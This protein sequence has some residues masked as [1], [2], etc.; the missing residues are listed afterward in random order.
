M[1]LTINEKYFPVN[2]YRKKDN[3]KMKKIYL[4][5]MILFILIIYIG[6]HSKI[7]ILSLLII[8]FSVLYLLLPK[9]IVKNNPNVIEEETIFEPIKESPIDTMLDQPSWKRHE[10]DLE[11][12]PIEG[13]DNNYEEWTKSLLRW[14]YKNDI[15]NNCIPREAKKLIKL[16]SLDLSNQGISELP[17]EIGNLFYLQELN[18]SNNLLTEIP[19]EISNL[20]NLSILNLSNNKLKRRPRVLSRL[21]YLTSLRLDN[22]NIYKQSPEVEAF[23]YL[24]GDVAHRRAGVREEDECNL[25]NR[26]NEKDVYLK[27]S[28]QLVYPQEI[29]NFSTDS[30]L[31]VAIPKKRSI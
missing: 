14:A 9:R 26:A 29:P 16:I 8:P 24:L 18:L 6:N 5:L 31:D 12:L 27:D 7:E 1:F 15:P 11:Q 19:D 22:N 3:S 4:I 20:K 30:S 23:N 17:P 21:T 28:S 25:L 13:I 2:N 10:Q